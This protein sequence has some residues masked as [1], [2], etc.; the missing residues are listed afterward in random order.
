MSNFFTEEELKSLKEA[1]K[2]EQQVQT[3]GDKIDGLL[4]PICRRIIDGRKPEDLKELL[5]KIIEK[6]P[7]G[8]HRSELRSLMIQ[9]GVK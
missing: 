6:F 9:L 1:T 7:R 8:F 3:L 2:L 4:D 5:P